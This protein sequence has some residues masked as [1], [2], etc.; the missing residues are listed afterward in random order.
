MTRKGQP[1]DA[2]APPQPLGKDDGTATNLDANA[3]L[4][5]VFPTYTFATPVLGGQASIGLLGA[6][7]RNSVSVARSRSR[8]LVLTAS[9]TR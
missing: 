7:G 3:D 8:S 2:R 5:F 4:Q 6:Y 1:A 9:A